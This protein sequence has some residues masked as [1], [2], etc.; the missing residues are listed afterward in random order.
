MRGR[1]PSS[2]ADAVEHY[3]RVQCDFHIRQP[4]HFETLTLEPRVTS[5]VFDSVVHRTI[6]L[7]DKASREAN[8]VHDVRTDR[9]L[10]PEF[11]PLQPTVAQQ[12]P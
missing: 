4:Q 8:E 12:L 10:A 9:H 3:V 2:L 7:D 1:R 6:G 11:E 5:G